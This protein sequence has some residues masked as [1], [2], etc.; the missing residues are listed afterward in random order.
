[1][2]KALL[3]DLVGYAAGI[4]LTLCFIPQVI[5][6]WRTRQ[7]DDVSMGMLVLT[8]G[9]AIGYEVYAWML[10]LMPVVV[11]NAIFG[12]LVLL[13]IFLK[14]HFDRADPSRPATP[15]S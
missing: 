13:E 7:A 8:L 15:T 1:M 5:K 11:M 12:G 9:S 14:V 10:G 3:I 2:D 4:L 6:T